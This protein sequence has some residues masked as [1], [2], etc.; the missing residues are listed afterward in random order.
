MRPLDCGG[1]S[2]LGMNVTQEQVVCERRR[3]TVNAVFTV[4]NY[5]AAARNGADSILSRTPTSEHASP[6]AGAIPSYNDDY[7]SRKAICST[8]NLFND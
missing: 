4:K 7:R 8:R 3:Y 5:K 2:L 6:T 1:R